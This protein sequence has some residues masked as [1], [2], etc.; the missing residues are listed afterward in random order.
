MASLSVA[1][2]LVVICATFA[3]STVFSAIGFG[4]GMV[5]IPILL[6]A[7][8]PQ[9]AVVMLNTVE[10]PLSA[11]M[12]WQNRRHLERGEMLPI[13]IAGLVGAFIGAF[14]LAASAERPLRIAII[15]LIITL[16]IVTAL[17]L[18]GQMPMPRFLGPVIGFIVALLLTALGI[19]GPLLALYMIARQWKRDAIRGSMSLL[20]MVVMPTAVLGLRPGRPVHPRATGRIGGSVSPRAGRLLRRQPHS[21]PHGRARIPLRGDRRHSGDQRGSAGAGGGGGVRGHVW[22]IYALIPHLRI[23]R[24]P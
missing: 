19:G 10:V 1:R 9:T 22:T 17:N 20:F 8:D 21:A 16:T 3:G 11:L 5:S 24:H 15:A 2:L 23:A 13:A 18:R 14:V 4:I 7:F 12:V 6:L